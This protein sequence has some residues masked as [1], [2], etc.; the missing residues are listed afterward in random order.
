MSRPII[1]IHGGAGGLTREGL[2]GD[3][4]VA[5]LTGL[6]AALAAGC[7]I[8]SSGGPALEAAIAAVCVME[9]DPIFNAGRG[10]VYT[11]AETQEMDASLMD[12]K[13]R[14]AGAVAAISHVK[15]P[16]RAAQ[17]VM[18]QTQHLLMVGAQAEK[19][20]ADSGLQMVSPQHFADARRLA[21]LH[22]AQQDTRILLDHDAE[23]KGTVG[24]VVV[25][26]AGNVAAATSTGGMTNKLP[27]RIG[28][29]AI[30]GAGTWA[31][32]RTCA[33]S[34]TGH[35]EAIITANTAARIS[36]RMELQGMPL[37]QA[38][39]LA[40]EELQQSGAG[41]GLIA[42][43]SAG[44]FALPFNTRGMLRGWQ[45]PGEDPTAQIW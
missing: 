30:I 22:R 7:S 35:G 38:A 25:D 43:D 1:V 34:C 33:V 21:Q 32:N 8:L 41:A 44:N 17:A 20:A 19:V 40:I 45:R 14:S 13:T 10:A 18:T 31:W 39:T 36:A 23:T 2:K 3:R 37:S 9:D 11:A 6:R 27:G 15:N 29:S 42:V 26:A 5:C 28:D 4:R 12:G 16:I 24:A